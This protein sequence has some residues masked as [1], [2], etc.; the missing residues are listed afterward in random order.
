[1][2]Y[3]LSQKGERPA[4]GYPLY[5]ALHGGGGAPAFV[6]DQQWNHMKQYYLDSIDTGMYVAARGISNN[7]NL[8][9]ESLS[10]PLYDRII[11]NL[12]LQGDVDP[13]RIYFLGFS[14]GGD[15]V[16]QIAPRMADRLAGA[17]MSAGHPN[18][19]SSVNLYTVP[20]VI[21]MGE[22]D[23]A[24]NR[25]KVAAQYAVQLQNQN[26][27]YPHGYIHELFLH[28]NG[29]HN[30]WRDNDPR[31]QLYPVLSDPEQWLQ[32]TSS[33]TVQKDSNAIRWL[34]QYQRTPYPKHLVWDTKTR[35]GSR[36]ER[37]N[38]HYWLQQDVPKGKLEV[39]IQDN[40]FSIVEA[41]S[42]FHIWIDPKIVDI[43]KPVV[44]KKGS[45]TLFSGKIVP[46]LRVVAQSILLHNDPN[47]MYVATIPI[48]IP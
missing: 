42:D 32:G 10:Y 40:V 17:N 41:H 11:D 15:G 27:Q 6:N 12:I 24:Y 33:E 22:R 38:S 5:I 7:W 3:S 20:F 23:S 2:R 8:H 28:K 37:A 47:R 45:E 21:Q 16:Y 14:A 39:S 4:D 34:K 29:S 46:D 1:M 48:T 13:N 18:G 36:G 43:T 30:S 31:K 44:V 9:F 19:T 26:E 35:A 25:N